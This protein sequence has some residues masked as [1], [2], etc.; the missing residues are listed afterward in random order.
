MLGSSRMRLLVV[1]NEKCD[2][3]RYAMIIGEI[4]VGFICVCSSVHLSIH[5]TGHVPR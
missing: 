2:T 3:D 5:A 4:G 1:G